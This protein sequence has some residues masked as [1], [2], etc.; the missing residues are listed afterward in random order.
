MG[1]VIED[2]VLNAEAMQENNRKQGITEKIQVKVSSKSDIWALGII[3]YQW[4][5]DEKHP[6]E[7]LPGQ[8]PF[9]MP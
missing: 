5:Y 8:R 7:S 6:Y 2:G 3:L 4:A 9:I 1:Y